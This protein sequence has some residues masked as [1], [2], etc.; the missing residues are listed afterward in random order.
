MVQKKTIAWIKLVAVVLFLSLATL[1]AAAYQF[2]D[3]IGS[4]EADR[5]LL[6]QGLPGIPT[7]L[8]AHGVM[9]LQA[10]CKNR[11]SFRFIVLG[12][13][14]QDFDTLKKIIDQAMLHHPDF[15]VHTG[16]FTND[17]RAFEYLKMVDFLKS[18]SLPVIMTAGNHDMDNYGSRLFAR[19]FGPP[20]FFFDCA[21]TRFIIL[22]N[23]HRDITS[24]LIAIQ[25]DPFPPTDMARGLTLQTIAYIE[26]LIQNHNRVFI[27]MHM[28]P[29][30]PPFDFYCFTRNG[31]MFVTLMSQYA[32]NIARVI[33]GHI[34]G[35]GKTVHH[36]VSYIEA[37][38]AGPVRPINMNRVGIATDANY[39]LITVG[40]D[41]ISDEVFFVQ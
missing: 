6:K 34:H 11:S 24:D 22:N 29:P 28:P 9:R 35:Y 27:I 14:H 41:G 19:I 4:A 33:F 39:V 16:D 32:P 2:R 18:I 30:V 12:D 38:G 3:Y 5:R 17:G 15:I 26:T 21:G 36:G 37:G 40:P 10:I 25:K 1:A 7:A 8:N 31:D 23:V 13:S 20:N